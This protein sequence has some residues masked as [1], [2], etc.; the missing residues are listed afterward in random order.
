MSSYSWNQVLPAFMNELQR[1]SNPSTILETTITHLWNSKICKKLNKRCEKL[2]ISWYL[3]NING[4]NAR[5][6]LQ[7]PKSGIHC[8]LEEKWKKHLPCHS[9]KQAHP[10]TSLELQMPRW[11]EPQLLTQWGM[12]HASPFQFSEHSHCT[13]LLPLP[14]LHSPRPEQLFGHM[15]KL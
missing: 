5:A 6:N 3:T 1:M 13:V 11:G 4:I 7:F 2:N 8:K 15:S 12:S 14:I 10:L 9:E